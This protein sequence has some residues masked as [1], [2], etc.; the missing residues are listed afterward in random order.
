MTQTLTSMYVYMYI[1]MSLYHLYIYMSLYH[2]YMSSA[3]DVFSW[4]TACQLEEVKVVILGQDPYHG[5][6]QAHGRPHPPDTP[7]YELYVII[8]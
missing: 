8:L 4:T 6:G 7:I 2:L 3:V 1:Y 5:E